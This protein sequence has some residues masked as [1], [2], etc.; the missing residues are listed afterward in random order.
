MRL[1]SEIVLVLF[2]T[3]A[4]VWPC[5]RRPATRDMTYE[6]AEF[7]V[8]VHNMVLKIACNVVFPEFFRAIPNSTRDGGD[9]SFS[10]SP[11]NRV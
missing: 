4:I 11:F 9:T 5:K 1:V 7:P 10:A 6:R 3:G 8:F 2:V